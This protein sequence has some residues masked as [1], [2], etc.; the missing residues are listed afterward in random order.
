MASSGQKFTFD[1]LS[2]R[3][4]DKKQAKADIL[5]FK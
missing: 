5:L 4:N 1:P 2:R 3:K